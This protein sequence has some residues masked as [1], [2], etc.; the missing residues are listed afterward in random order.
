[1][2]NEQQLKRILKS[3]K[4][5][6]GMRNWNEWRGK[7]PY[8]EIHLNDASLNSAK[9]RGANLHSANLSIANLRTSNLRH[10]NLRHANSVMPIS[11]MLISVMPIC[12]FPAFII[13]T[14]V[15]LTSVQ[16]T[17][18]MPHLA[19]Q[20]LPT[21]IFLKCRIGNRLAPK[22]LYS[23]YGYYISIQRENTRGFFTGCGLQDWEIEMCK[24]YQPDISQTEICDVQDRM[25]QLRADQPLQN[26]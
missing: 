5:N 26:F 4:E 22:P 23:M 25:F 19:I 3:S 21:W 13:R 20:Y 11:V 9:L 15:Q 6:N 16:P 1:M 18:V 17:S 8:Q 14:S 10:A 7:N 2:A 12:V 24:L